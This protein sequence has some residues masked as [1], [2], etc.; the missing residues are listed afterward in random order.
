MTDSVW[1]LQLIVSPSVGRWNS[2]AVD[3]IRITSSC[4]SANN[5]PTRCLFSIG[6]AFENR[7]RMSLHRKLFFAF[8]HPPPRWGIGQRNSW[9]AEWLRASV[10]TPSTAP[11]LWCWKINQQLKWR[12]VRSRWRNTTV[13]ACRRRLF[14][15]IQ[16]YLFSCKPTS[17]RGQNLQQHTTKPLFWDC[18]SLICILK[19]AFRKVSSRCFLQQLNHVMLTCHVIVLTAHSLH[20]TV[21]SLS[22]VTN[23]FTSF[24]LTWFK[25]LHCTLC[26]PNCFNCRT[27][28]HDLTSL[29]RRAAVTLCNLRITTRT[30]NVVLS[31][32]MVVVGGYAPQ[33]YMMNIIWQL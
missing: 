12:F 5:R 26:G 4:S 18:C 25:T 14:N 17:S 19:N 9:D 30:Q 8:F 31:S 20:C 2:C 15:I 24:L 16:R 33:V 6:D 22:R 13:T 7:A 32:S 28:K 29:K 3:P 11:S 1:Q 27:C 23:L 10:L 21:K